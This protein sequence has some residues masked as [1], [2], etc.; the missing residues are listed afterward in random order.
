MRDL[1]KSI[2]IEK[3]LTRRPVRCESDGS[4][5]RAQR[6]RPTCQSDGVSEGI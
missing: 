3:K 5:S 1:S 2:Y 4:I 6:W